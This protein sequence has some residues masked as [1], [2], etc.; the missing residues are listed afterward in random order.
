MTQF[1]QHTIETA[2]S[3]S[4]EIMT[5]AQSSFGFVPNL[6]AVLAESPPALKAYTALGEF[7]GATNL[8]TVEQHVV[9]LTI[10]YEN[11][12]HYC[13]PGHTMLAKGAGVADADIEALREGT[14]LADPKLEALRS[15]TAKVTRQ[16]G[17]LS[18]ADTQAFLNAG[19]TTE[20]ILAVIVGQAHKL[21]SNYTNH[22]AN[23]PVDAAFSQLAWTRPDKRTEAVA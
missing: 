18:E 2:P 7:F 1:T 4:A 20:H 10:N 15:F 11:N 17:D 6:F 9:W 22:F 12:C 8:T 5:G 3:D 14:P 21:I 23:T 16:R 19:Y 13:V